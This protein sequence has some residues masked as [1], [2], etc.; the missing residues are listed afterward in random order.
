MRTAGAGPIRR[1]WAAGFRDADIFPSKTVLW[2]VRKISGGLF[3][4][5][6]KTTSITVYRFHLYSISRDVLFKCDNIF[7]LSANHDSAAP[8]HRG[9]RGAAADAL[10]GDRPPRLPCR[11]GSQNSEMLRK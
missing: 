5:C 9:R 1:G 2:L 3:T 11:A 8:P 6:K 10:N 4:I 7:S